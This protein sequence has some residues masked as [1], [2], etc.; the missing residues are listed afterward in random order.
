M[1]ENNS[2]SGRELK[3]YLF[4]CSLAFMMNYAANGGKASSEAQSKYC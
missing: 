3:K 4:I 1:K 2:L